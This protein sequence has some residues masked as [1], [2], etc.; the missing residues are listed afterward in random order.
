MAAPSWPDDGGRGKDWSRGWGGRTEVPLSNTEGVGWLGGV[1]E[2]I[3]LTQ[4]KL[5]FE[6]T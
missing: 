6:R 5:D 1:E 4:P 2:M 3:S